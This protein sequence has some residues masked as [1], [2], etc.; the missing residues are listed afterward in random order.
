VRRAKIGLLAAL[1]LGLLLS[2]CGAWL[3]DVAQQWFPTK[4]S[5][6]ATPQEQ[7]DAG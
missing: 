4:G 7:V 1:L 3:A 2:G 6:A 5:G